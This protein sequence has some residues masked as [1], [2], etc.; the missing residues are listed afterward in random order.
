MW[1]VST[2]GRHNPATSQPSANSRFY[3]TRAEKLLISLE[4]NFP[5]DEGI[6]FAL[7]DFCLA[8]WETVG[9]YSPRLTQVLRL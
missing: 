8:P 2:P 6:I 4:S 7:L 9:L 5:R 3:F 1:E